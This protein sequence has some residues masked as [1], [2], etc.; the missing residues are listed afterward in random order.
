MDED[1][2]VEMY[3]KKWV[4]ALRKID[5]LERSLKYYSDQ[6]WELEAARQRLY[7]QQATEWR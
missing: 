3:K 5:D 2:R 1:P 7:E 4:E 6:S